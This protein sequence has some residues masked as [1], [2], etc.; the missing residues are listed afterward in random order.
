MIINFHEFLL[1]N[2]IKR[3][4]LGLTE[5]TDAENVLAQKTLSVLCVSAVSFYFGCGY[6]APCVSWSKPFREISNACFRD[7]QVQIC[8]I[9]DS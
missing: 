1:K 2:G 5:Q 7:E 8:A 9:L 3:L 6:A 4:V